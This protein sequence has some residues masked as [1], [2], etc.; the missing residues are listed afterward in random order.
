MKIAERCTWGS[1]QQVHERCDAARPLSAGCVIT[2]TRLNTPRE[3][4]AA[5]WSTPAE[6]RAVNQAFNH[7]IQRHDPLFTP[8]RAIAFRLADRLDS[9]FFTTERLC[10]S[11]CRFC[12][13]PCC[14]KAWAWFD[15]KDLLFMHLRG[16]EI[17][18]SQALS[19]PGDRCRYLG[20]RGCRLPRI[21]RPWVGTWYVCP[22]QAARMRRVPVALRGEFEQSVDRIKQQR[23]ALEAAFIHITIGETRNGD[24]PVACR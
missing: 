8:T 22:T 6:W 11:T 3:A 1:F 12:P 23:L 21:M 24:G 17:P 20:H 7:L 15:F 4:V 19:A 5:P 13:A 18:G 2:L 14:E 16:I 10:R 9:L